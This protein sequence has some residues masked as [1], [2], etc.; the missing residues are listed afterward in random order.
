MET[1]EESFFI[2]LR[3]RLEHATAS[4]IE[5]RVLLDQSYFQEDEQDILVSVS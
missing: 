1:R 2:I 4:D 3:K 5:R